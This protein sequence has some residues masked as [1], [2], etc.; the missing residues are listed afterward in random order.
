MKKSYAI[1]LI[2]FKILSS[3]FQNDIYALYDENVHRFFR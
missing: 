1:H 3:Y 2:N